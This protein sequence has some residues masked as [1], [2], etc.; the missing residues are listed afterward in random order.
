MK[1]DTDVTPKSLQLIDL[2]CLKIRI[3]NEGQTPHTPEMKSN[4][5]T[6]KPKIF[7]VCHSA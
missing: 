5:Y 7:F 3:Y 4:F 1:V 2:P 6:A